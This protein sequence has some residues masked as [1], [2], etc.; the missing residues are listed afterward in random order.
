MSLFNVKKHW[1]RGRGAWGSEFWYTEVVFVTNSYP[2]FCLTFPLTGVH[3][4]GELQR[5]GDVSEQ[6]LKYRPIR[7][8]Q[9]IDIRLLHKL[10]DSLEVLQWY[11]LLLLT[12]NI[13]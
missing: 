8:R 13:F 3:F 6:K 9:I 2:D 11:Y 1:G 10:Y 4:Q 5:D 7:T 12:I